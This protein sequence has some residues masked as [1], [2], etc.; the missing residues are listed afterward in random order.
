MSIFKIIA[1]SFFAFLAVVCVGY[2][3][4]QSRQLPTPDEIVYSSNYYFSANCLLKVRTEGAVTYFTPVS[5]R[6]DSQANFISSYPTAIGEEPLTISVDSASQGPVG[7]LQIQTGET[8]SIEFKVVN[9]EIRPASYTY[10]DENR[11][12]ES[13]SYPLVICD[14]L[15]RVP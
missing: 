7:Q 3:H 12:R 1:F 11:R 9:G 13:P 8:L 6:I 10:A 15:S 5:P 14:G 2:A 4:S